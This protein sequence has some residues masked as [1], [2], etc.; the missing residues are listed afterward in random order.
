MQKVRVRVACPRPQNL[1]CMQQTSCLVMQKAHPVEIR[2]GIAQLVEHR[3]LIPVVVGS[4]P[5]ALAKTKGHWCN[6]NMTDSKSVR[7]GFES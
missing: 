1:G 2:W 4:S 5:T 7:S 3:V 6:G